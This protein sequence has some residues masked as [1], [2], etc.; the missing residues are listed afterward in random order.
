MRKLLILGLSPSLLL[1][2]A[3][4]RVNYFWFWLLSRWFLDPLHKLLFAVLHL[5]ISRSKLSVPYSLLRLIFR[6]LSCS[7]R[8]LRGLFQLDELLAHAPAYNLSEY[9]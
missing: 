4:C 6:T 5:L 7:P 8:P 2:L 1:L 3:W 9:E